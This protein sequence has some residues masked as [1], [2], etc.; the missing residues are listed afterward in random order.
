MTDII[1]KWLNDEVKLSIRVD[2]TNFAREFA[3]GF[4]IGEV[5]SKYQMQDDFEKFSQSRTSESKLNN[6]TRVE[7]SLHTLGV[8][9]DTNTAHDIMTEKQG[10][11]TRLMY[12][13]F[14]S[15]MRK[16]KSHLTGA[17]L[18]TM[19]PAAP[20]K[21]EAVESLIYRERLKHLTPRQ[22]DLDLDDLV[23]RF[24]EKQIQM[25]SL[26]FKERFEEEQKFQQ[27]LADKRQE[28]LDKHRENQA[29]KSE[30]L[31]KIKAATVH[32]PKPPSSK[33]AKAIAQ[34]RAIRRHKEAEVKFL[35]ACQ[36]I[37][38]RYLHKL[39]RSSSQEERDE[40]LALPSDPLDLIKPASNEDYI[41]RIR[42]RLNEDA[43]AREEREKR[44]R[45]V[46]VDQLKAHDA[47]EEARHEEMLVNRLMRQSQQER[48]IAVQL[49]QARHEKEIIRRNR[50]SREKE[51]EARRQTEFQEA[52]NREA[53]HSRLAKLE[54]IEQTKN[55]LDLHNKIMAERAEQRYKKHYDMSSD[56]LSDIVDFST[57]VAEYRELTNKLL[58]PKLMRD[59][60]ELFV[61]GMPQYEKPASD[62]AEADKAADE[63]CQRLLDQA[64]FIEYKDM[65]GEWQPAEVGEEEQSPP[66][67]N[68]IVGHIVQRLLNLVHPPSPPPTAPEFPAF[69][70]K[71]C[72]LGKAFAGKSSTCRKLAENN[73]L[74]VLNV[75]TLVE[76]A[77]EAH[78]QGETLDIEVEYQHHMSASL[79]ELLLLQI[80]DD[81]KPG[82]ITA[83]SEKPVED[84]VDEGDPLVTKS[85]PSTKSH[86]RTES[87]Q[88]LEASV[89][90]KLGRK[91][92][93]FLKRGRPVDDSLQIEI[94]VEAIRGL[95][96]ATGWVLDGFPCT[97][98]QAKLLEKALSGFDIGGRED[99]EMGGK[100]KK[101][102]LAL[103][104][105]P[106]AADPEPSSGI[107]VVVLF[108]IDNELCLKRSA[109]RSCKRLFI[110]VVN[111]TSVSGMSAPF[112]QFNLKCCSCRLTTFQDSWP[113][114]EKWFSKFGSLKI[115]DAS[116]DS[117][118]IFNEVQHAELLTIFCVQ[119][120]AVEED[121]LVIEEP[122]PKE[123]E[124]L[125]QPEK[126]PPP[127][128]PTEEEKD[129]SRPSSKKGS[130][131]GSRSGSRGSADKKK[132]PASPEKDSGGKKST[133]GKSSRGSSPK[134]PKGKKS[135]KKSKTP[136][137][138][139]EPEP[140]VPPGTP[141]PL[142]G[143]TEWE[144]VDEPIDDEMIRI[145]APQWESLE[146]A[147]IDNSKQVFRNL[148]EE[149]EL[150][151]QYF[152]N[153]KKTFLEFLSR[154]DHKQ[155]F[156]SQWQK[157]FNAIS[158]DLRGDEEMRCELH[159]CIEDLRERLW[160][161]CDERKAQAESEREG[162]MNDG[163]LDDHLGM[164]TNH[165]VTQM[166]GEVDRFQV[167]VRLLKDYYR[168]M[169]GKI[170][171]EL[172]MDFLRL[173][174]VEV[175][176]QFS[177]HVMIRIPLVPRRPLSPDQAAAAAGAKGK[178][179]RGKA[180]KGKGK[181]GDDGMAAPADLDEKLLYDAHQA[182]ISGIEKVVAEREREREREAEK[183]K[184]AADA[185]KKGKGKEKGGKKSRSPSPK[186][187][188]GKDSPSQP[189]PTPSSSEPESEEDKQ[190][191]LIKERAR[192]E[193]FA[194]IEEEASAAK[195]RLEVILKISSRVQHMLK[196][197]AEDAYTDMN[198]W[199]GSRFLKEMESIDQLSEVARNAVEAGTTIKEEFILT[200]DDFLV[201]EDIKVLRTPSPPARPLPAEPIL[202][203]CFTVDQIMSI[204]K[205]FILTAPGGLLSIKA[206]QDTF[207]DLTSLTH[208]TGE[209]PDI[210]L[211]VT[212]EKLESLS[213]QLSTTGE[214][215][216]WR[217]FLLQAAYPWPNPTQ[218]DLLD[219]L[220]R[221]KDMDQKSS[222]CV[223]REQFD[224]VDLWFRDNPTPPPS[225]E[226]PGEAL[227]FNRLY[228]LKKAFFD[229]FADHTSEPASLNYVN[230][231]MYFSF[232][233]EAQ[234]G[235]LRALS[236]AA[237]TH[238]PRLSKKKLMSRTGSQISVGGASVDGEHER[239][240]L[241]EREDIPESAQEAEVPLDALDR[242]L[243]QGQAMRGDSHRFSVATEPDDVYSRE[244]LAG[245]Y[246]ELGAEGADVIKFS[247][248]MEHPIMQD[249]V[250]SLN[251]YK[252]LDIKTM[253]TISGNEN[254]EVQST[255]TT[256]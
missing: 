35:L 168:G 159:Q 205:Q 155:E 153:I 172:S 157:D 68:P 196:A 232:S 49:L 33:T 215:I 256:D 87:V 23:G 60:K 2:S 75:D 82:D 118:V 173:P 226:D 238:M 252:A 184:A 213:S 5:L 41:G 192:Q 237:G 83:R 189:T 36:C 1:C 141:P 53:E 163:W 88:K 51:Y 142:P 136:E 149:R 151:I 14:V 224:R 21:L 112:S 7:P 166:Q 62:E 167:T 47:Q 58:P 102:Q 207:Q 164:M 119:L 230:M 32:I 255:K 111:P 225:S 117:D 178:G 77:V 185:K 199:L 211:N 140:E 43:S 200:Q 197:K 99:T 6:L 126:A 250:N 59:W 64:D 210:W 38:K 128:E 76:E 125:V 20:L 186:K 124:K 233:P 61:N 78:K 132:K 79:I 220:Q 66:K 71:A 239:S 93:R 89:R 198:D 131:S 80:K 154:P 86:R 227:P 217:A 137:P 135:A 92:M 201:S 67:N 203:D 177:Y 13:V 247:V 17:A 121:I 19:R 28:L 253:L 216:D 104:P 107:N 50:L 194:A 25:E 73:R 45:K 31:A 96:E 206:F 34:R 170:P 91:A 228:H 123:E 242:V 234:E 120:M 63:E 101:S 150:I 156:V 113:K 42:K 16:E 241:Y 181:D 152:Y 69:P 129:R 147:Y 139:P 3:T 182:A 243:H 175:S 221:F 52:L 169:E 190:K 81:D 245:V 48:R 130:R 127:A 54:Y 214:Y 70:I 144:Y 146:T 37:V 254:L 12:Q 9:Y 148:R 27:V 24:H 195:V 22:T 85:K 40:V 145:L 30:M 116:Q 97:P 44:R 115:I 110:Y 106:V 55:D 10:V 90:A 236:V 204:Y 11:A 26:A 105:K 8:P 248:L 183:Q 65:T 143:S 222:G 133:G 74:A 57:K 39:N 219:T 208:G 179:D 231:L 174:L 4:L 15:I 18:E 108:D 209:I 251:T 246:Q 244:R 56:I 212:Q 180:D 161:I 138:E 193:F 162:V 72:M 218:A 165:Y 103:D 171:D 95:P 134:S 249:I 114:M 158:D 235:F 98:S 223:S 46:L 29:K 94:L 187:G 202:V 240:N 188:K 229:I 109:G 84:E 191:K 176:I 160:T 122:E 100:K